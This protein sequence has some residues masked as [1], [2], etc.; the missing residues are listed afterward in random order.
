MNSFLRYRKTMLITSSVLFGL[1]LVHLIGV[2][3]Y[4][5]GKYVGLPG[6][7]ISVG[8]VADASTISPMNP[9][10]YGQNKYNDLIY[11]LLFRSL[12][13][14]NSETE[15]YEGDL[16]NCDIS[17]VKKIVCDLR[18]DAIW[19]DGS[20]ITVEDIIASTEIF[21]KNA[22]NKNIQTVL[23]TAKIS[24]TDDVITIESSAGNTTII[25]AL[26]YPILRSDVVDQI[27][28][29]RLKKESYIVS[30][31]FL[32]DEITSN[33]EHNYTNVALKANPNY[34]KTIFLEKLN[35]NIFP[36]V[37]SLERASN[38]YS[39]A[40]PPAGR[41]NL[42]LSTRFQSFSYAQYEFF[43]LFFQTSR[44]DQNIRNILHKYLATK[45]YESKIVT[46]GQI[47]VDSIF[48]TGS[49][50]H[51]KEELAMNFEGFMNDK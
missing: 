11:N 42:K 27:K 3:I 13:R 47:S 21:A 25:E 44:I 32:F 9:L 36:D 5:N 17:Q 48:Q 15:I 46:A 19:S 20:K 39:V 28:N 26:T 12:I 16:A 30:G 7:S 50:I 14:Y 49:K 1:F 45:I 51:G 35:I 40:I 18:E 37:S 8:I 24:S 10:L 31:P 41:E 22:I 6:G 23:K 2:Y 43:G 38:I 34:K 29:E 4:S 33:S